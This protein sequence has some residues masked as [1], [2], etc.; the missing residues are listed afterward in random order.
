MWSFRLLGMLSFASTVYV[1]LALMQITP[2]FDF[3]DADLLAGA[4]TFAICGLLLLQVGLTLKDLGC[5]HQRDLDAN[6]DEAR[7]Y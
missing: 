4:A 7:R 1:G 2:P 3:D 5:G 6:A